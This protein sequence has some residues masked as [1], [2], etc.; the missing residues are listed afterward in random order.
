MADVTGAIGTLPGTFHPVPEG[1][2]CDDHPHRLAVL[3]VQGETDSFGAELIDLCDECAALYKNQ[4]AEDTS[5]CCAW[6]K[7]HSETL[8][9]YRDSEEGLAGPI[10]QV[11]SKCIHEDQE[12]LA[13]EIEEDDP[14]AF[15]SPDIDDAHYHEDDDDS[16]DFNFDAIPQND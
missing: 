16:S 10:Y 14:G 5:G 15:N 6:C 2:M 12:K 7:C 4:A 3:R 1:Q 11:C 9:D 8:S 13:R